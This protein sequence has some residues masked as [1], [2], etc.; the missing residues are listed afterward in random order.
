MGMWLWSRHHGWDAEGSPRGPLPLPAPCTP[1]P[2]RVAFPRR[3]HKWRHTAHSLAL[4]PANS[5]LPSAAGSRAMEPRT[6]VQPSKWM[7]PA[8]A[9]APVPAHAGSAQQHTELPEAPLGSILG[10]T[11]PM[12]PLSLLRITVWPPGDTVVLAC[13]PPMTRDTKLCS[14]AYWL[15]G[16]LWRKHLVRS[17]LSSLSCPCPPCPA[18]DAG[19]AKTFSCYEWFHFLDGVCSSFKIGRGPADPLCNHCLGCMFSRVSQSWLPCA[20][21]HSFLCRC[22]AGASFTL[23]H[24]DIQSFHQHLLKK[25]FSPLKGPSILWTP[26]APNWAYFRAVSAAPW[27]QP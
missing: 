24:V 9:R 19:L 13:I 6:C 17:L 8:A 15:L 21:L 20:G 25:L 11:P 4:C 26:T 3:P 2:V 14:R 10:A 23:S 7:G 27:P 12:S 22:G 1:V 18:A 16:D 5:G